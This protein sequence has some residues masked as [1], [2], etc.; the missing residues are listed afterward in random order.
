MEKNRLYG[1][2][3]PVTLRAIKK[4]I[5]AETALK[6][7]DE[8]GVAAMREWMPPGI[9]LQDPCTPNEAA[10]AAFDRTL[11]GCAGLDIEI[12]G[13]GGWYTPRSFGWTDTSAMPP[14]DLAPASPYRQ[15]LSD[16]EQAWE[17]IARRFP[18]VK[19][20]EVGNEWNFPLFLHPPGWKAGQASYSIEEAMLIACD[21]MFVSARGIRRGN[22]N[23]QVVSFSPTP[24][25]MGHYLPAGIP[26]AY[27]IAV[28]LD[29]VYRIIEQGRSFSKS[30]DDYFDMVAWH[31]YLS[32]QMGYAPVSTQ[33]PA[34]NLYATEDMPDALWKS[35]NDEAYNIMARHG[36]GHKKVLLTEFGFS[37]ACN[38]QR[39]LEQAALIPEVFR[40]LRQ[41]PYVKSCHFFRLFE[42]E[43]DNAESNGVFTNASESKFGI[44]R[45]PHHGYA[46][47]EKARVL[48]AVYRCVPPDCE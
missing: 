37:D 14:R 1:I 44:I 24:D 31:P 28:A 3:E 6:L 10:C 47:R 8:L 41:M 4:E 22:R 11:N 45:E 2:G 29:W 27:G 17:T 30:S 26:R 20:W 38:P 32:T 16:T 43:K 34:V 48:Q 36:D 23:A 7:M 40:L 42:A 12:T 33:Y 19:Q 35:Y 15:L 39:E 46:W 21:L 5:S 9:L 13:L 25:G 18:Q